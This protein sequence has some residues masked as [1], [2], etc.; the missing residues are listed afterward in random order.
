MKFI[1]RFLKLHWKL[2]AVTILLLIV[3][4][5]GALVISTFAAEMLNLGTS[6]ATLEVLFAIGLKMAAAS[7]ISSVC[8][9]LGG[10]TCAA[11]SAQ[12]GKDIRMAL[13][14]KSLK[15]SIYD[16]RS[17]AS[18]SFVGSEPL[19]LVIKTG[20]VRKAA[21]ANGE[22]LSHVHINGSFKWYFSIIRFSRAS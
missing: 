22:H 11:L 5:S 2:C 14:K 19:H 17:I 4:V 8:A 3:D 16:F 15:L 13:Y 18:F 7:L 6:G 12:V 20:Y 9:I 1:L 21:A 10:Y